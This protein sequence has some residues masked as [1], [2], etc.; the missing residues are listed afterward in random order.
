VR[1]P[2]AI[3]RLIRRQVLLGTA[4]VCLLGQ[5][6]AFAHL[7][8]VRH[9]T[10][11]E[12]EDAL[13]H[14]SVAAGSADA[15]KAPAEPTPGRRVVAPPPGTADGHEDDHCLM[16]AFRRSDLAAPDR[17]ADQA[18]PAAD[19]PPPPAHAM[20]VRPGQ[21]PLLRLAPKNSPPHTVG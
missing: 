9:A 14:A 6:T 15:A 16:A 13:V 2:R 8:L 3:S 20:A 21:V 11:P 5:A 7:A 12:H 19:L 4:I 10:C 17:E 1:F 18:L